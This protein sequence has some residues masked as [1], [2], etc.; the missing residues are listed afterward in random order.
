M[1]NKPY[2]L[3]TNKPFIFPKN[4]KSIPVNKTFYKHLTIKLSAHYIKTVVDLNTKEE[5]IVLFPINFI[6]QLEFD[7]KHIH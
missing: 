3:T 1:I 7:F 6:R 4:W 5:F 2:N